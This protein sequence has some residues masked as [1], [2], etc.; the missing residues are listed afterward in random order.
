VPDPDA[1]FTTTCAGLREIVDLIAPESVLELR[2]DEEPAYA[3]AVQEVAS[4]VTVRH[5]TVSSR[6]RRDEH[7]P[8]WRINHLHRLLRHSQANLKRET[9]AGNKH[10]G[11]LS[12]RTLLGLAWLNVTKGISER[13]ADRARTTPAMVLG[14]TDRQLHAEDLFYWRRFPAREDLEPCWIDSYEGRLRT[15]P[16][17][18]VRP[19]VHKYAY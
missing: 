15:R 6:A 16:N 3:R 8:L 4:A 2:S 5:V 10:S 19:Y 1:R 17:E 12:D 13:R 11:G 7:N 14:L 18:P 9:I